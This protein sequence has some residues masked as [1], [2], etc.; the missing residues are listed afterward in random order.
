DPTTVTASSFTLADGAGHAVAATA[1][2]D[3]TTRT[4]TLT[5]S[6][7]LALATSYT[8]RLSTALTSSD[9]IPLANPVSWSFTTAAGAVPPPTAV[10]SSPADGDSYVSP[11]GA[12]SVT[13]SR[14]MNPATI[15]SGTFTLT[16]PGG[17]SV[18]AAV[19]YDQGTNSATFTPT[20]PLGG[21][22]SYTAM[23]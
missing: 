22:T 19:S 23:V 21:S 10:S 20:T 2:Y 12:V 16:G 7:P 17:G 4:A 5:P 6:S 11:T 18:A 13:F 1:A 14:A 8:V 15:T 9:G 3:A